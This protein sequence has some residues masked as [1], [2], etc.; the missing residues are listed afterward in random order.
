V[1]PGRAGA[2]AALVWAACEPFD[3]R[4]FAVDYS[5]VALLGKLVTRSRAWPLAGLALHAANGAVFGVAAS[6]LRR[7]VSPVTLAL[8]EST[9][10][11]PLIAVVDRRHPARGEPG[12]APAFNVRG[13]A[14]ETFRHLVFGATLG[15]LLRE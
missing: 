14:L 9:V 12:L 7:R 13:L 10:L 6:R 2:V 3:R 1:R 4:L 15:A 5:D 11:F 8:A